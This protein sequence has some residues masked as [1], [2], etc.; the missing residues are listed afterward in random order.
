M[1]HRP[2]ERT[3]TGRYRTLDQVTTDVQARFSPCSRPALLRSHAISKPLRA[4]PTR[5]ARLPDPARLRARAERQFCA[6]CA[7]S[8]LL[9]VRGEERPR[10]GNTFEIVFAVYLVSDRRADREIAHGG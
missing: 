3:S 4:E 2:V 9:G 7:G 10:V 8:D 6:R 5:R 1:R